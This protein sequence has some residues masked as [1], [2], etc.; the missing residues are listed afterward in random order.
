MIQITRK[1]SSC[2]RSLISHNLCAITCSFLVYD[3][4]CLHLKTAIAI[5]EPGTNLAGI[6]KQQQNIVNY[7][8]IHTGK[9]SNNRNA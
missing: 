8:S 4:Y 7:S 5:H 3:Q 9:L 2:F 6:W 1:F